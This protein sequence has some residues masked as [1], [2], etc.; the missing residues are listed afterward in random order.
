M[1]SVREGRPSEARSVLESV[2]DK[3]VNQVEFSDLRIARE[4]VGTL[5]QS[6]CRCIPFLSEGPLPG[7]AFI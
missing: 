4:L 7:Y 3:F 2:C 5:S 1:A 6:I